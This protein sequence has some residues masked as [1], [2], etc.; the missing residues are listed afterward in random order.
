MR[1]KTNS[2]AREMALIPLRIIYWLM[3]LVYN[4]TAVIIE[5]VIAIILSWVVTFL[6]IILL[7]GTFLWIVSR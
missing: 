6:T 7:S 5:T 4:L 1:P 3:S 2:T